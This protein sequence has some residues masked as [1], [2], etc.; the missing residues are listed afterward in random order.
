MST[1]HAFFVEF[2]KSLGKP[3]NGNHSQVAQPSPGFLKMLPRLGR[4]QQELHCY[5]LI[6][7]ALICGIGL[8]TLH[9]TWNS[10]VWPQFR[11]YALINL[12]CFVSLCV[13][14]TYAIRPEAEP[15]IV[16]YGV[17]HFVVSL[18]SFAL[19]WRYHRQIFNI[20]GVTLLTAI[21][22]LPTVV[23]WTLDFVTFIL[24]SASYFALCIVSVGGVIA[25]LFS[26]ELSALEK[27]GILLQY[28]F[29]VALAVTM[30][31]FGLAREGN[32]LQS[33]A[34]LQF[35]K[36]TFLIICITLTGLLIHVLPPKC[37]K[38]T[39]GLLNIPLTL[40]PRKRLFKFWQQHA[41]EFVPGIRLDERV[42]NESL[43]GLFALLSCMKYGAVQGKS[44][45]CPSKAVCC[46]WKCW[47]TMDAESFKQYCAQDPLLMSN[48][49]FPGLA[50]EDDVHSMA[51]ACTFV[52]NAIQ[53]SVHYRMGRVP[54]LF[55]LD[56]KLNVP[57]GFVYY[58]YADGIYRHKIQAHGHVD[59]IFPSSG[60]PVNQGPGELLPELSLP[61]FGEYGLA[62]VSPGDAAGSFEVDTDQRWHPYGIYRVTIGQI[63]FINLEA[64]HHE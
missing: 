43:H 56:G 8:V 40:V 15:F 10:L 51:L 62:V 36:D 47:N 27:C 13:Q 11:I 48:V 61:K 46:M 12:I 44:V 4:N 3:L 64:S 28:L 14:A 57:F 53:N 38:E 23:L 29:Q 60:D 58:L 7:E 5:L 9:L 6:A 26:P 41:R 52:F 19:L 45:V 33:T 34:P 35:I 63:G 42:F 37:K 50:G 39:M 16:S 54:K 18:T 59:F 22:M 30:L 55:T 2:E 24:A 49:Q 21:P 31:L 32:I 25:R 17:P 20:H 1:S